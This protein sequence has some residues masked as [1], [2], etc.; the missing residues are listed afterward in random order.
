MQA[1]S[2][3]RAAAVQASPAEQEA[4]FDAASAAVA[5]GDAQAAIAALEQMLAADPGLSNIRLELGYLYIRTGETAR[6][7]DYVAE[8]V[9]DPTMPPWVRQ[10]AL[11]I[12]AEA[13]GA[14]RRWTFYG[15]AT[16]GL[17]YDTNANSG[18]GG[19]VQFVVGGAE[20]NG[21]LGPD[22]TGQPDV[23]AYASLFGEARRF[24][25][26]EGQ[27]QLVLSG[28]LYTEKYREET[29]LDLLYGSV[30]AG[31]V[32]NLGTSLGRAATVSLDLIAAYLERDRQHYLTELG[33]A[34]EGQM[35]VGEGTLLRA[36]VSARS[37][38]FY[39]TD[40]DP[41]NDNQ[42]GALYGAFAGVTYDVD[43]RT[44]VILDGYLRHKTAAR[45][46][47]A[48]DE[49]GASLSVSRYFRSPV[50]PDS[51]WEGNL[52]G[53]YSRVDYDAL[54]IAIDL[55]TAQ[56]DRRYLIETSLSV[57]VGAGAAV[58][59]RVGYFCNDSNFAI[60]E[61]DN[62]YAALEIGVDF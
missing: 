13:E 7:K 37:Q 58:L 61:Y 5:A 62:T 30:I 8:A 43:P 54:D 2:A 17:R 36:G 25:G 60:Q 15:N 49:I 4:R 9:R 38:E 57:P 45:D 11:D 14:D 35:L 53:S 31:P 6:G 47:E 26:A 20:V 48:Y 12:L 22:D 42:D 10:R 27:H 39:R 51:D 3:E 24:L 1:V 55:D 40:E 28:T 56:R 59:A 16:T 33:L 50:G 44:R 19:T 34:A 41:L 46:F 52:L 21:R 32:F 18:P 23:S 29:Q